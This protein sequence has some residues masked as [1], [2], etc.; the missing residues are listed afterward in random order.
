MSSSVG[1]G[2]GV[3]PNSMLIKKFIIE[4][5]LL[6]ICVQLCSVVGVLAQG[7]WRMLNN[8]I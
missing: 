7:T 5:S 2:Q 4:D 3:S 6:V 1:M 8:L